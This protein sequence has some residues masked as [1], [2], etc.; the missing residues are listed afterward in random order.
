MHPAFR[1]FAAGLVLLWG[2]GSAQAQG[3]PG[4]TSYTLNTAESSIQ[5]S[6]GHFFVSATDGRFTTFDGSLSV[7]PGAPE[8]GTVTIHVSPGSID[9]GIAARDE[10]LRTADFFDAA[11][12]PSALFVSTGLTL[13]GGSNG[14]LTG[15]LT[16]HGA[17]NPVSLDAMLE[18][19]DRNGARLVF[20][21]QG[22]LKRSAFGMDQY[23]GVIGDEVTLKIHAVFD[24]TR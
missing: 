15:L 23:Q 11:R 22:K 17:T 16:L 9:T 1:L 7:P 3:N 13:T 12:Y 14:A 8:R 24:R 20:S 18:T 10:H 6:I 21:A 5:F 4:A 2:M 19:P